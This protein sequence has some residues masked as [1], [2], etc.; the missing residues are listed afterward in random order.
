MELSWR[1]AWALFATLLA[2][3]LTFPLPAAVCAMVLGVVVTRISI[4]NN[5]RNYQKIAFQ[6]ACFVLISLLILFWT[7]CT[8]MPFWH[9]DWIRHLFLE[10]KSLSQWLILLVLAFFL[11]LFWQ[12]GRL[13]VVAS[14]HYISICKQFDKTLGLFMVLLIVYALVDVQTELNLQNQSI[15]LAILA[16]FAFSLASIVLSRHQAR[17]QKS[18]I[19]GYHGIGV[20]LSTLAMTGIFAAGTALL[21]Y[22]YLFQKADALLVI[23]KNTA[24]P[25]KP[26]LIKILIF[27]FKPK[28]LRQHP[29]IHDKNMLPIKELGSPVMEGWRASFFKMLVVGLVALIGMVILAA[30]GFAVYKLVL[31]LSKRD[32]NTAEPMSLVKRGK[33]FLKACHVFLLRIRG[34]IMEL[35]KGLDSA[36]MIYYRLIRWGRYSGLTPIPSDTPSEYGRRLMQSFPALDSEI[37]IIV[38]AFNREIYGQTA[39]DGQTLIQLASAYRRMRRPKH[40]P[41]RMKTWFYQS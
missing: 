37:H 9:F 3:Q 30:L 23:L 11:W 34:K 18:F 41:S 19:S 26:L 36:A 15:R 12:G 29:D 14:Q 16:F 10:A 27:L 32:R 25:F 38:E 22:P 2:A 1:Y 33:R 13:L 39:I 28:L 6:S 21:V 35:V 5:F 7:Q 31:W 20:V 17:V 4:A 8:G 40:W 24:A